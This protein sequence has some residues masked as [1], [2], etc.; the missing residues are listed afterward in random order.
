M[1]AI[2]QN[3][4]PLSGVDKMK[5]YDFILVGGGVA[6]LTLAYQLVNSPLADRSILIIDRDAKTKNDRTLSFWAEEPT[7]FD[8]I[9]YHAWN[10][11][12]FASDET[13][14]EFN[15]GDY[16]YKTI[17][18]ID[19]YRFVHEKLAAFSNVEFLRGRVETVE[20]GSEGAY[21]SVGEQRYF[22]QWVFDSR[23]KPFEFKHDP[24]FGKQVLRQY[25]KGWM[26]ETAEPIFNPNNATLF[27]FRIPQAD[28][29]R[30]FYVLP[31]SEREALIEYVGL[32]HLAYDTIMQDY[33]ENILKLKNYTVK[34]IEGGA[35]LLTDRRFERQASQHVLRI[36]SA[37]GMIKPS[38]GY[39]F[40][41]ILKDSKAIVNS[42]VNY[43]HPF[44]LPKVKPFY[45]FLDS[46]MIEAMNRFSGKM[47][48][49]FTAMF[50]HN[51]A[52]NIFRFLDETPTLWELIAL[53]AS[54]PF[55]QLFIWTVLTDEKKKPSSQ[56]AIQ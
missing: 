1:K 53:I 12:T 5:K 9:V 13:A 35:I 39:A 11:I 38:S 49:I 19:L 37:G 15:L 4:M 20:E 52:Q 42:L 26:L 34:P 8:D 33:V 22:G 45:R 40:T 51:P 36:G 21:V 48:V 3:T 24:A 23:L 29:M 16:S 56:P 46:Q 17:R 28:D 31:F 41:R 30:F 32:K 10:Q 43:G 18:G 14:K 6:G 7:L 54:L 55:K 25:F 44:K 47:K 2:K 27:D 50:M